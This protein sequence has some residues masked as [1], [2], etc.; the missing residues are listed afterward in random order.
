M[1]WWWVGEKVKSCEVVD[2]VFG[3]EQGG[4][5]LGVFLC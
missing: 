4:K 1:G 5:G 2:N 3:E